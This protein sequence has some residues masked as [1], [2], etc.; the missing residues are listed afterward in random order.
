MSSTHE[1]ELRDP[2]R[3]ELYTG[4]KREKLPAEIQQMDVEDT[5]CTFCGVSYFVFAEVQALQA[6]AKKY[7]KTFHVRVIIMLAIYQ[8]MLKSCMVLTR[9][10]RVYLCF[11]RF[12]R[13]S[14]A[15]SS[16]SARSRRT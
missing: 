3:E 11:Y 13:T 1:H 8:I 2:T 5:A 9:L 14:C 7:K 10:W 16:A 4:L 6:T 12:R 15:S